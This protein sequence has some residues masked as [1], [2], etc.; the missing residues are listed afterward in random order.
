MLNEKQKTIASALYGL[1]KTEEEIE[2][3]ADRTGLSY[4]FQKTTEREVLPLTSG[5][6]RQG[7]HLLIFSKSFGGDIMAF[8]EAYERA[9]MESKKDNSFVGFTTLGYTPIGEVAFVNGQCICGDGRNF[10]YNQIPEIVKY[11]PIFGNV[12]LDSCGKEVVRDKLGLTNDSFRKQLREILELPEEER[13]SRFTKAI[14]KGQ[15]FSD[16]QLSRVHL[17]P[18]WEFNEGSCDWV[19]YIRRE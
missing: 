13:I 16:F 7:D 11:G 10:E 2:A 8:C 1:P 5:G 9:R 6:A 15:N 3:T 14:L 4:I 18:T 17:I 19:E 12:R